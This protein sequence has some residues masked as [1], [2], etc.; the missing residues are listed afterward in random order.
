MKMIRILEPIA[1]HDF[2]WAPGD[3]VE[4]DDATFTGMIAAG[5]GEAPEERAA[6]PSQRAEKRPARRN[7]E[8]RAGGDQTDG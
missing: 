6:A 5:F 3:V 7:H 8:K 1:G 2:S 4:V